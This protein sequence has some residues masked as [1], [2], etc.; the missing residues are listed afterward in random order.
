MT[1]AALGKR[2]EQLEQA[3]PPEDEFGW[4]DALTP[5]ELTKAGRL[6]R[7]ILDDGPD[8]EVLIAEYDE[9]K[10]TAL[11]RQAQSP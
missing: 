11:E 3:I 6:V 2:V 9:L 1:I 7:T 4:L 5:E 8:R 10:R